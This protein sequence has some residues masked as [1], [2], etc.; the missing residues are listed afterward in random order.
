LN[1]LL[2]LFGWPIAAT[3][4]AG[5]AVPWVGCFLYARR[6]SFHGIV[7]PQCAAAGIGCGFFVL[8]YWGE[9][10]GWPDAEIQERLSGPHGGLGYHLFWAGA[11]TFV[12]LWALAAARRSAGR[13]V[14][15]LAA[16]FAV[17]S[18]VTVIGA[19][20][21]PVGMLFVD[22]LMRGEILF[23]GPGGF[24]TLAVGVTVV[25]VG[26]LG[27]RDALT[28]ASFDRDTA[29]VLGLPV[30]GLEVLLHA[31][32]GLTVTIGSLTVGPVVLFG[33]LVL[34]PIAACRLA[35]SMAGFLVLSSVFGLVSGGA[36][37]GIALRLDLP[38][39]PC[40]VLFGALLVVATWLVR[41]RLQGPR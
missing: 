33:L 2:D 21:S 9:F 12:G 24:T 19:R 26:L 25:G 37:I 16:V 8:P 38:S 23:L 7:L 11:F 30:A 40:I 15:R 35:R 20:R 28:L 14:G 3:L 31:L 39:G 1:T 4:L 22:E 34:P 13:E 29:Q 27:L 10:V 36:G 41:P 32:T 17:A 6:T 18:A 5:L